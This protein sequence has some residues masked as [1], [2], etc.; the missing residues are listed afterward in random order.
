M[1]LSG[2]Q[3]NY[4]RGLAHHRNPIVTIGANGLSENVLNEIDTA[5]NQHELLKIKLP[6]GSK[7]QRT[8]LVANICSETTA[9]PVQLLGRVGVIFRASE[10]FK[11]TL[12]EVN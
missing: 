2:K 6:A 12:P 1:S 4:L 3:K 11:I 9:E 7:Q 5:L 10:E 8:A